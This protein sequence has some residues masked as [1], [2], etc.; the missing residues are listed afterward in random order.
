[1]QFF[2]YK[3]CSTCRR[4]AKLL[5]EVGAGVQAIDLVVNPPSQD[6]LRDL[7]Q[8]SG[9]PLSRFFNV[10]GQSYRAGNFKARLPS[11]SEEDRYEALAAD[12]KLIKRPIL[13]LG[14]RVLVGF[15]EPE[16]R[17]ALL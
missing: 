10:S 8:R 13:D 3:G 11:M 14:D 1:M 12:G 7:H 2:H 17:E 15:R 6:A 4:A 16:W 5:D 9:L